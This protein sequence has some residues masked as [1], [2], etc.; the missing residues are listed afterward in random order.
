MKLLL[1][2]WKSYL[3]EQASVS[4]SAVVL[5]DNSISKLKQEAN[6]IIPKDFVYETKSGEQLPHHMTINM[7]PLKMDGYKVGDKIDLK[8]VGFGISKDAIAA[9]VS[10]PYPID[11][12]SRPHI[13]IAIPIGGKPFMSNK[14]ETWNKIEQPFVVSGIV[15]EV[16][17]K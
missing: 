12:K 10:P 4:Y 7:G 15:E 3:I 14:I 13:T 11:S 2:T 6:K 16:P 9:E 8:V 5:D 1:E 17:Q